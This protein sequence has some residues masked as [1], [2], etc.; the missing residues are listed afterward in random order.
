MAKV[1]GSALAFGLMLLLAALAGRGF[2]SRQ[3]PSVRASTPVED[4]PPVPVAAPRAAAPPTNPSPDAVD[5]EPNAVALPAVASGE[6]V[7]QSRSLRG[8][9]VDGALESDAAGHFVPSAAAVRLFD[10]FLSAQGEVSL[11]AIRGG[12]AVEATKQLS[13]PEGERALNLFDRYVQYRR[14]GSAGGAGATRGDL[15]GAL[16]ATRAA[17]VAAFGETDAERMFGEEEAIARATVAEAEARTSASEENRANLVAAAES[18]L[19]PAVRA[20]HARRAETV[21]RIAALVAASAGT[22]R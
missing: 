8:T 16:A 2:S 11:E 17:R 13:P 21:A 12:V 1:R 18:E 9:E 5:P 15:R 22:S 10:Y 14:D 20:M 19:P 7:R 3:E 4:D 6:S